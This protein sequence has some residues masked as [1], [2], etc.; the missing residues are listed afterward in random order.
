MI[1]SRPNGSEIWKPVSKRIAPVLSAH[2]RTG[3]MVM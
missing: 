3:I 2:S 1:I